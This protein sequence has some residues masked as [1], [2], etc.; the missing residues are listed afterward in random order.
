MY[1]ALVSYATRPLAFINL[2]LQ[3]TVFALRPPEGRCEK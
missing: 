1:G 2:N 3:A